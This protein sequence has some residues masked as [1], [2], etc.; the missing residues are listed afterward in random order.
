MDKAPPG[1]AKRRIG[2]RFHCG[3]SGRHLYVVL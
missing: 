1:P 2:P 3:A